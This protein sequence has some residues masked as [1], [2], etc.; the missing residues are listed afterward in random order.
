MALPRRRSDQAARL[1]R[2]DVLPRGEVEPVQDALDVLAH[3]ARLREACG[4]GDREGHVH[5][6]RKRARDQR[7]ARARGACRVKR[8]GIA[9]F[10]GGEL[11]HRRRW[12]GAQWAGLS[13]WGC[14]SA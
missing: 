2:L 12:L 10:G 4:V 5:Q 7:L 3:V 14:H 1:G 11:E 13:R 6:P 8:G 9:D